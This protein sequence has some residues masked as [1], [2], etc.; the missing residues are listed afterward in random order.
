MIDTVI[1]DFDG[2]LADTGPLIIS[3]FKHIHR[4]FHDRVCDEEY[5][6]STFGE[7]LELT[8]KRDFGDFDFNHV[9]ASYREYQN[10]KFK[11]H[12]KLYDTVKETLEYIENKNLKMGI[13][14][15]RL[16]ASTLSALKI[17][18][19]EEY[20]E[21]VVC[22]DDVVNHKPDKEPLIKVVNGLESH[23]DKSLYV[24]DSKYDMESAINAQIKPVLVGWHPD[25]EI[26]KEKYKVEHTLDKMWDLTDLI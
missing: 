18:N 17:L 2:T 6:M 4:K 21:V 11:E 13:A 7:P 24:G 8:L 25:F 22:V 26:L 16:R 15:S 3:S 9:L 1:F 5:I 14:T 20:F 10:G 23:T 12:V 19:I